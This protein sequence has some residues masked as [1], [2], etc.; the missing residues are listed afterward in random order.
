MWTLLFTTLAMLSKEQGITVLGVCIVYELV[1]AQQLSL[2]DVA[3]ACRASSKQLHQWVA[4][5]L[6]RVCVLGG[7]G[8]ALMLV[9]MRIMGDRL[10]VFTRFDNPAAAADAPAKQL[11]FNYLLSVNV[12]L[13]LNPCDL[14]CDWTMD[15]VPLVRSVTDWRNLCTILT[16]AGFFGLL[17]SALKRACG[18]S[19]NPRI[20]RHPAYIVNNNNIKTTDSSTPSPPASP[21]SSSS[22]WS[23]SRVVRLQRLRDSPVIVL[24]LAMM[25]V[26]FLPASNLLFPVGF[27]VAE[28][29]LY[30]PS[31]GFCLLV[32][33]GWYRLRKRAS[34]SAAAKFCLVLLLL[35]PLLY[36]HAAKTVVRNS[37]WRDEL[38]LFSS[39]LK[40]A[41]GNAK[42]F[43]N[44][45]HALEAR[46][47]YEAALRYFRKAV[48][49]Q[50]DDIGAYINIGRAL[51]HL[52]RF[53]DAEAAYIKAKS[54]LPRA[55]AGETF[56]ARVAPN[57][58]NV[59]LNLATLI[60][61]NGSRLEEADSLYRQ[62]ISM[63]ADYTQAYINRGDILIK[64]N[65]SEEAQAVYEK[66]LSFEA[67]N[68]DLLYNMG[69][70]MLNQ[71]K[72]D[73]ALF[74][75]NKALQHD[76]DH[77][78]ALLNSAIL[79]QES[80]VAEMGGVAI[81]RLNRIVS[82]GQANERVYFNLG[83]LSMDA[84]NH[85]EAE[86]WF[87]KAV[88][89]RPDFRSALFNLALLLSETPSREL[90]SLPILHQLIRHHPDHVKGLILLGDLYV[91]HL[92]DLDAADRCYER[93]L[94]LD[95]KNVQGMHNKCVVMVERGDLLGAEACLRRARDLAPGAKY[96]QDHLNIVQSKIEQ[97][98]VAS[99]GGQRIK[100]EDRG[101]S[102]AI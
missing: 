41:R 63:R 35:L 98:G 42:L 3:S 12:W 61:K 44:V 74:Y 72:V 86:A 55:K 54:L 48:S 23:R 71:K 81:D 31:M 43:N 53:E 51:N 101:R 13:L 20:R 17:W 11:T 36:I 84:N 82:R 45:G 24:S 87:T 64:L 68:P 40:V 76:P 78:Q 75:L 69:V 18:S 9:R 22:S 14:C 37:E 1:I 100:R 47:E 80:G 4:P 58:L 46:R 62:A 10:P 99:E 59:F 6:Q 38:S 65:R 32:A 102:G 21:S 16:Y 33:I 73:Q 28:R 19:G 56:H 30:L 79:I 34:S 67:D 49:V 91:N 77:P 50:P 70:V 96:V 52:E 8:L 7:F 26:P 29:V 5:C 95:P 66:A 90:E 92:S 97:L 94:E 15:T 2:D 89:V 27:V 93:I 25:L 85:D 83:M 39:G 57:H 88:E 60:S